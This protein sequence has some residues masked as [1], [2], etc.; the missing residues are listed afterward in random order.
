MGRFCIL[1]AGF[2]LHSASPHSEISTDKGDNLEVDKNI[3]VDLPAHLLDVQEGDYDENDPHEI[4]ELDKELIITLTNSNT[5]NNYQE[6]YLEADEVNILGFYD[7]AQTDTFRNEYSF[8]GY[9]IFQLKD[10]TVTASDVYD[11]EKARLVF[12]C[13]IKNFKNSFIGMYL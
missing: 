7:E 11:V 2:T 3:H 12:Q 10:E 1:T 5:S 13:D 8:E 4:Q 9:Q 6:A